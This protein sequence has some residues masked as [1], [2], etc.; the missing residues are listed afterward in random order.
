MGN[1]FRSKPKQKIIYKTTKGHILKL[2]YKKNYDTLMY[3]EIIKAFDKENNLVHAFEGSH[4]FLEFQQTLNPYIYKY[5][6]ISGI[7]YT[8]PGMDTSNIDIIRKLFSNDTININCQNREERISDAS[9]PEKETSDEITS[10]EG[11]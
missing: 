1:S 5:I 4:N 3:L 10:K 6:S 8:H 7:L 11:E 2:K 9:A